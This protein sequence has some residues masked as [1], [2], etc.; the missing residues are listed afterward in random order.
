MDWVASLINT[1]FIEQVAVEAWIILQESVLYI[2]AGF[3]VAGLLKA[4]LPKDLVQRNLGGSHRKSIIK[5]SLLG[6][7]LP[8]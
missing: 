6:I 4:F 8:L 5:A 2:F 7:P 1:H 3:M